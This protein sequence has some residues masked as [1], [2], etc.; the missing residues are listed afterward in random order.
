[1]KPYYEDTDSGIVIYHA[2][3]REVLPSVS[4]VG[5][6]F[7]SP[8][9]NLSGDGWSDHNHVWD[10]LADGYDTHGD[11]MEHSEYRAWQQEV[12]Q[13]CW[14]SLAD[15]GALYYNHKPICRGGGA[16]KL[17]IELIAPG[18][19]IRQ[20]II[21]DRGSGF[22]RNRMG[23]V[24]TQEWILMVAKPE[25]RVTSTTVNDIWRVPFEIGNEHPAPFPLS[26]ARRAI[27][28]TAGP[29][30]VLDPFM[31][32]GTTLRAAKDIGR[33]AIGIDISE[34]YCEIAAKRLAQGVL[35]LT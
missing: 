22:N 9:Y 18:L 1:M 29:S 14:D 28:T 32:S 6:V 34:R 20:I 16:A 4:G 8:P 3:C 21:W 30:L 27:A 12:T 2:D 19:P 24:P 33:R 13:L 25:F 31:G 11:D 17:P 35:E 5:L 26:L 7:T 23:Y 15:D 10:G